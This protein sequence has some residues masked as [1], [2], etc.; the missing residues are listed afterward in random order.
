MGF[1]G[2]RNNDNKEQIENVLMFIMQDAVNLIQTKI[3]EAF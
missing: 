1:K 3:K 2:R